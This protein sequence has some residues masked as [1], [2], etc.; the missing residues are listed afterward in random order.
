MHTVEQRLAE[1]NQ[2]RLTI[3]MLMMR[4]R[5]KDFIMRGEDK[6]GDQLADREAEFETALAQSSLPAEMKSQILELIRAYKS[7]F[8]SFMV[9][10]QSLSDQVDDLAQ[11]YDRIRPVLVKIMAAADARSR[12]AEMRS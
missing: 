10:Q 12:A 8:M 9:T 5:E 11:I 3:L 4:R 2:P 1:L 6:Y 7:S